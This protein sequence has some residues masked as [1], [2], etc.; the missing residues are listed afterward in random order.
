MDDGWP[1]LLIKFQPHFIHSVF[2]LSIKLTTCIFQCIFLV[3]YFPFEDLVRQ[4]HL[5]ERIYRSKIVSCSK[6]FQSIELHFNW[7]Q[8]IFAKIF[9]KLNFDDWKF[10]CFGLGHSAQLKMIKIFISEMCSI[11]NIRFV[12]LMFSSLFIQFEKISCYSIR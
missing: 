1:Q 5:F 12:S 7:K 8:N 11:V 10:I 3:F 6:H 9:S 2:L 4:W